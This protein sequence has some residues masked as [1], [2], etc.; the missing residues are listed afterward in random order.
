M[1][2]A[3]KLKNPKWQKKRLE[4]LNRDNFCC[5]KCGDAETELR[6]HHKKYNGNPWDAADED[7]ITLCKICHGF[8]E[9]TTDMFSIDEMEVKRLPHRKVK[10]YLVHRKNPATGGIV[11][12]SYEGND[13]IDC[14]FLN[15]D[16]VAIIKDVLKTTNG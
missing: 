3:E 9:R 7:L 1:T 6:V 13:F 10:T 4:I 16:C 15:P 2:Y 5:Q 11:I 8:F 14:I 12:Y